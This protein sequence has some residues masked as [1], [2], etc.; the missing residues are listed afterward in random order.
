MENYPKIYRTEYLSAE[1]SAME[2]AKDGK[3]PDEA[4]K[5]LKDL[6]NSRPN[7][8][9]NFASIQKMPDKPAYIVRLEVSRE[10]EWFPDT[11]K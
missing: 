4:L 3:T 10:L 6:V 9:I 5:E 2:L 11:L 1:I 8:K 7:L